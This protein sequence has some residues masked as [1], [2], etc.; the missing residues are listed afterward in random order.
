MFLREFNGHSNI[1]KMLQILKADRNKDIYLVFEYMDTDLHN[2]IKKGGI[3]K[4]I[5][6]QYIMYQVLRAIKYLHSA[7]VIHRDLKPSNILLDSNCTAKLA[8]FGLARSLKQLCAA[9]TTNNPYDLD[10]P[11]LTEYVATRWYRA[12]EILLAAKRYTMG[13]DMWSVGTVLAEMLLEKALFPGTS[14]LNQIELIAS[15]LPPP[16]QQDIVSIG[17]QYAETVLGRMTYRLRAG[18]LESRLSSAAAGESAIDLVTKLLVFNP[19]KRLTVD[20]AL[21]Q[22]YL[23]PFHNPR[24]EPILGRD[25]VLSLND[26]VQ[27]SISAYRNKLYQLLS[28]DDKEA[29]AK[30]RQIHRIEKEPSNIRVSFTDNN[31]QSTK[32]CYTR[33]IGGNGHCSSNLQGVQ[34]PQFSIGESVPN[35]Q[36]IKIHTK[37]SPQLLRRQ[38]VGHS[39]SSQSLTNNEKITNSFISRAHSADNGFRKPVEPSVESRP[40]RVGFNDEPQ[41]YETPHS[42]KFTSFFQSVVSSNNY[43][44]AWKAPNKFFSRS[45]SKDNLSIINNNNNKNKSNGDFLA[46]NVNNFSSSLNNANSSG[47][48]GNNYYANYAA[49]NNIISKPI[50][51]YYGQ[52]LS[53]NAGSMSDKLLATLNKAQRN[54]K[55]MKSSSTVVK[56][57][58]N[59]NKMVNFPQSHS[60][61]SENDLK[62]INKSFLS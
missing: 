13:V 15:L 55:A 12:P 16:S 62:A 46:G 52:R 27:L 6:K 43:N 58:A 40:L 53:I 35:N 61:I 56:L 32:K 47:F 33:S 42:Q 59:N 57:G 23:A 25:V 26:D 1:V 8:D 36:L 21:R 30:K 22:P 44:T 14:T 38:A 29:E 48:F 31:A 50:G 10:M 9:D 5:H 49:H 4:D 3:L 37:V 18:T 45:K 20:E 17:S 24:E 28:P 39:N 60:I 2:V 34:Q 11:E 54:S 51:H 7:N 41:I 19:L